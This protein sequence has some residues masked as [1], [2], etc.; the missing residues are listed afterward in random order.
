MR[1]AL[2]LRA[3]AIAATSGVIAGVLVALSS[4]AG[5]GELALVAPTA[6]VVFAIVELHMV[7]TRRARRSATLTRRSLADLDAKVRAAT[8]RVKT[9]ERAV[10]ES[11]A[12]ATLAQASD[13]YPLPLGGN[14]AL[15]W[16]AAVILARETGFARPDVVVELGSG[17][18]SLVIGKQLR[19][20]G[21]GHL[22]SLDHDPS[23]AALTRQHIEAHGLDDWVS[24][25]DAP[26]VDCLIGHERFQWYDLPPAVRQLPRIDM[27]VVDGPPQ[28]TDRAGLPRFPA[29]PA[30]RDQLLA[31][32]I[33]FVDDAYREAEQKM[34]E[35]WQREEPGWKLRVLKT[36]RGTALLRRGQ[37]T[38]TD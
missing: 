26:L 37:G 27:L 23:F 5:L 2:P 31:G 14:W 18:S 21:R 16:D 8:T 34:L 1:L 33:V 7:T 12:M 22:Y 35:R 13:P 9:V 10:H 29:L 19:K 36:S 38:P 17:G 15:S 30:F 24:V 3:T 32:S 20:A 11:G 28:A 4:V 25:L 6:I